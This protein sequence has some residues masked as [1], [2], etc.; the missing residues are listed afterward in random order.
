MWTSTNYKLSPLNSA[1]QAGRR[2]D[3][4]YGLG[5]ITET[6]RGPLPGTKPLFPVKVLVGVKPATITYSGRS[7][8]CAR[9]W[10]RLL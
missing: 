5:A 10:T 8:C 1:A 9:L 6:K 7:G 4:G 2:G 3:Y